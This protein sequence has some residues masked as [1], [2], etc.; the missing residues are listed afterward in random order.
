MEPQL[1]QLGLPTSLR[2]DVLTLLSDYKVCTE[3]NVLTPE[4]ACAVKLFGYELAEF[5]VTIKYMWDAQFERFQNMDD[6][7]PKSKAESEGESEEE[8]DS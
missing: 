5:K 1:R 7:L 2:K 4:Q 3:G 8:D 6:D